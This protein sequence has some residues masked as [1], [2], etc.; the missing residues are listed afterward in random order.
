MNRPGGYIDVDRLQAET[1]LEQAAALCG[2]PLET[3]GTGPEVRIDCPFQC[4]GDHAGRKEVAINT[5]NP[6][7]VFQ[8]HAYQCG[9]R[10]NMLT[11]MHGWL[12][13]MIP[14]G[15]KLKG[16]EFQR[17]KRV[18]A[19]SGDPFPAAS[20]TSGHPPSTT[21]HQPSTNPPPSLNSQ[22]STLN[23]PLIDSP[24]QRVR[25][26]PNIAEKL[27]R[28]VAVMNPAAASYLRRHPCLS[29]ESMTKW[30]CGYLPNDGGS[31]KR[32]WSLRGNI[33][34]PVLSENGKVLT[35]VGRDVLH[36]AK[37]REFQQ[38]TP[39][40][41]QGKEP[42]A[43]HRFP[44]GFH[45]GMEL[46]GQQA[47]RLQEPGYREFIQQHGL[48]LVEGF[49]DVIGLDNLGIPSLGIMSN[50]MT[51]AQGE[52]VIRF[53]QQLGINRVNLMFDCE[54]SGTAGAKEALWYFA[55][56]KINVR[57]VWS[58][59]M[60]CG[61]FNGKQPESLKRDDVTMLLG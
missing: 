15:G 29:P 23:L 22:P 56:R 2:Y 24:D 20:S 39:I 6:Q 44:K 5:E 60:H 48:I 54:D 1:T 21:S 11:L 49:N 46:Y 7:K 19:R 8:C 55:E 13:G 41:R 50:R 10:G 35:W 37:E 59:T 31:D 53:A 3:K 32:G 9:F 18:L 58:P 43:K 52:K 61:E 30:R 38:L 26:L 36:E 57:L 12:A 16:D 17:V 28:D 14:T 45:R 42:P 33:L 51:D 27:I 34:Y 25:E 47:N 40:E 4:P